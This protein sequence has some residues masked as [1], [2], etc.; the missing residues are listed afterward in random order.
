MSTKFPVTAGKSRAALIALMLSASTAICVPM[1]FAAD[2]PAKAEA[3]KAAAAIDPNANPTVATVNGEAIKRSE[4][5]EFIGSL[6]EQVRQ[7]PLESLFP[8][9]VDQVV[10][11]KLIGEKAN[12]AEL[13][14][15]PEVVKL[16]NQAKGQIVRSVYVERQVEQAM[17]QKKLVEAYDKLLD[18]MKDVEEVHAHHILFD[19]EE[20]ARDAIARLGKGEDFEK[21]AKELSKDPSAK[22]NSGDLGFFAK[23]EMV[24]EFAT[25][26]FAMKKGEYSKDPVKTQ[27]GWHVIKIDDK[28]KRPEPKFEDVKP[29]LENQLR[30]QT[31]M[32][33]LEKWQKEAKIQK[34]DINGKPVAA[35]KSK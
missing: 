13:A 12:K 14:S 32:D 10:N 25:A 33:L 34:F 23:N 15:D 1:T 18:T 3:P 16:M 21:M 6:P 7:M 28:R 35:A 26:A 9:A 19:S 17:T 8:L 4:V 11:N 24:P 30:Q 27:F 20:K 5:L 31:L 29:Q 2:A 22:Q